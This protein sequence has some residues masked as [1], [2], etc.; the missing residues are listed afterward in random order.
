MNLGNKKQL[1]VK[2]SGFKFLNLY[3]IY[4]LSAYNQCLYFSQNE[5]VI[6]DWEHQRSQSRSSL[7]VA[8]MWYRAMIVQDQFTYIKKKFKANVISSGAAY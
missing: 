6:R 4:N 8:F 3:G 1:E 5:F 2:Q 7:S